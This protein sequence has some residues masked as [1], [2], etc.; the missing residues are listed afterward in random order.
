MGNVSPI[1]AVLVLVALGLLLPGAVAYAG[2]AEADYATGLNL[3]SSGNYT[4]A[5]GAFDAAIALE[6]G[7]HEAWNGKADALNRNKQYADALAASDRSLALDPSYVQGWINRGYILYNLG[8]YDD[9]LKAYDQAIAIDPQNATAWFDRGY[10]LAAQ[11]DYEGAL[12]AFDKVS[13]IDPNYPYLEGNR[14]TVEKYRDAT[15]PFYIR[16][17]NWIILF[18]AVIIVAVIWLYSL[19]K[20]KKKR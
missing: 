19:R 18:S 6:P 20:K 9:E 10:S 11:G 1:T 5:V 3:I 17:E 13:A 4:G 16:Y 14:K 7:Y 15:L 8:R 2:P 12:Q